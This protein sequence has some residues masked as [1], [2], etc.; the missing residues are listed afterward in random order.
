MA[1]API[2]AQ[3]HSRKNLSMQ[4]LLVLAPHAD[5]TVS[6]AHPNAIPHTNVTFSTILPRTSC[7][8][9]RNRCSDDWRDRDRIIYYSGY[10]SRSLAARGLVS[11]L[12]CHL[13][14]CQMLARS[15]LPSKIRLLCEAF[16][17]SFT[18]LVCIKTLVGVQWCKVAAMVKR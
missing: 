12:F 17:D 4:S 13:L 1:S 14:R 5:V 10:V 16:V 3:S 2:A 6:P 15:N 8:L 9:S 7:E 11:C 18:R